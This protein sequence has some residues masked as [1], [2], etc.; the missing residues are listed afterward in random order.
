MIFISQSE[1]ESQ[2]NQEVEDFLTEIKWKANWE[3]ENL[4]NLKLFSSAENLF[5]NNKGVALNFIRPDLKADMRISLENLVLLSWNASFSYN[6]LS[7]NGK[8]S[9]QIPPLSLHLQK[10]GG[11]FK[12]QIL[13]DTNGSRISLQAS[14]YENGW[15]ANGVINLIPRFYDLQAQLPQGIL[16]IID[17]EALNIRLSD[18]LSPTREGSKVQFT[19]TAEGFSAL[20][21][22]RGNFRFT[23]E[24]MP[25]FSIFINDAYG[26]LGGSEVSGTYYQ[27]W[28][29]A[30]FRFLINGRCHPPDINNWLGI[31]WS[32]LWKDFSFSSNI[33]KG[34]FSIEGIWDGEAGNSVTIG[35]IKTK[36]LSFRNFKFDSSEIN[37]VVDRLSTRIDAKKLHHHHG[38]ANGNLSFPR[39]L[40]NSNTYL[41]FSFDG[42][43]P[44]NEAKGILGSEVENALQDLNASAIYCEARGEIFKN[45]LLESSDNNFSWF[46]LNVLAEDPFSYAGIKIDHA[47]GEISSS[48]GLT[49]GVFDD[50]G[51][52]SGQ[53]KLSFFTT[54]VQSEQVS[55]SFD[56]KNADR[57][58]LFKTF[59]E[60]PEWT[61]NLSTDHNDHENDKTNP[62]FDGGGK[63]NFSLQAE[64]PV[65][66]PKYF[67]GTGNLL[68]HEVDI[69]SIH[70]LGGV[71]NKLGTFNLPLPS[72]ALY[73]NK[74][75]IP[76]VLDHD[77]IFFDQ[78]ILSGPL[79]KFEAVGEVNWVGQTVDLLADFRLAGNLNI[80][81]LKQIVNFA[82]PLSKLSKLKIQG[83]LENPDWTVH[84]GANSLK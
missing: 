64:G 39:S 67:E 17:G 53:G 36:D 6:G 23:G 26:K 32:P 49:K 68:I 50:L 4:V 22:P 51:L 57:G 54:S 8:V 75:E 55:L 77:R 80:P 34:N 41:T 13:S 30:K 38:S 19:V 21:T 65:S 18:N 58:E 69:G 14:K 43:F 70:I 35:Q 47:R 73:F 5:F 82:D 45:D 76:F 33:P 2:A 59:A 46:N 24:I 84:L 16:K 40:A 27:M 71:R 31:W 56:L 60:S 1:Q 29:P 52:A 66:N 72:D 78:A 83:D 42:D 74:L 20:E 15:F 48:E 12:T 11:N 63:V 44:I 61:D 81:V 28:N 3:K 10:V 9:G 79:S 37:L 7:S 62:Y 25:D